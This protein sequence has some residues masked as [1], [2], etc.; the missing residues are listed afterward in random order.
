MVVPVTTLAEA[1]SEAIGVG[2]LLASVGGFLLANSIVFR[3]PRTLLAEFFG[4]RRGKLTSIRGYIFHRLQ[5]HLGF[6]FLLLGFGF[7]LYGH[8]DSSAAV[9][10]AVEGSSFPLSWVGA[11]LLAVGTLEVTGWW[12]S[13]ALFRRYLRDYFR[14]NPPD[15]EA[16]MALTQELGELFGIPSTGDDTVQGYLVRVRAK[17]GLSGARPL[18]A[19]PAMEVVP[20]RGMGPEEGLV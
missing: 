18:P 5:I 9:A 16:D 11:V 6:F 14:E 20:F 2:L 12:L 1:P 3:H 8:Y 13:H 4:G 17:I 19:R 15:L 10:V 7:Q